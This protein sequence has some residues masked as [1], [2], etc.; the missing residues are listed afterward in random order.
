MATLDTLRVAMDGW[1]DPV[2]LKELRS[3]FRGW[4]FFAVHTGFLGLMAVALIIMVLS[5]SDVASLQ[6]ARIGQAIH[7]LFL[8]GMGLA[9]LLVLPAFASTAIVSEREQNTFG[10]LQAT[11]LSPASIIR[12]KFLASMVYSTVFLFSSLPVGALAFLYGGITVVNLASAYGALFAVSAIA[13]IFSIFISAHSRNSRT[14]LGSTAG[15]GMIFG[16]TLIAFLSMPLDPSMARLAG[17]ILGLRL[18]TDV[19]PRAGT[20]PALDGFL[21]LFVLPAFVFASL[22]AFSAISGTNRIKTRSGNRSTNLKIFFI[23]FMACGAALWLVL[24]QRASYATLWGHWKASIT[25]FGAL[26]IVATLSSF[27]AAEDPDSALPSRQ[28][29]GRRFSPLRFLRPGSENGFVFTLVLN[30]FLMLPTLWV[31]DRF[32]GDPKHRFLFPMIGLS[33]TLLSF[34][35]LSGTIG[36]L[37]STLIRNERA[38]MALQSGVVTVFI[39]LPLIAF[40][41]LH[42]FE[43]LIFLSPLDPGLLSPIV[44]F[45]SLTTGFYD[46]SGLDTTKLKIGMGTPFPFEVRVGR[47]RIPAFIS[48]VLA[49]LLLGT[50]LLALARKRLTSASRKRGPPEVA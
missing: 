50:G 3:T 12:G 31:L 13:N 9:I 41:S 28:R 21:Y 20:A 46:M 42:R 43:D 5:M 26:G 35:Y 30:M 8:M 27:F 22:F 10:L 16:A 32:I 45:G 34:L 48:T 19:L 7:Q 33:V 11:S 4:K 47:R 37:F 14:A 24:L 18:L 29:T 44:A 15:F 36:L 49:H 2:L 38:R 25:F 39:F 6:P 40:A 1:L 23:S 17:R